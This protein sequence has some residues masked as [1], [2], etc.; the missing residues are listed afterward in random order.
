[1]KDTKKEFECPMKDC[2]TKID[3]T[4]VKEDFFIDFELF[5]A[6]RK[7]LS[8]SFI[9]KYDQQIQ[10]LNDKLLSEKDQFLLKFQELRKPL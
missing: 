8:F 7:G 9:F 4:R 3:L 10:R 2:S 6:I 1:M 5:N